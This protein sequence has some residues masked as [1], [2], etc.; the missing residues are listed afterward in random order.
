MKNKSPRLVITGLCLQGNKGGPALGLSLIKALRA[1]IPGAVFI[2]ALPSGKNY[3]HEEQW[4]Q[5]YGVSSFERFDL[6]ELLSPHRFVIHFRDKTRRFSNMFSQFRKADAII[7]LSGVSYVGP[8][9]RKPLASLRGR[10]TFYALSRLAR[11][12]FFAWTQSYGPFGNAFVDRLA[13]SDLKRQKIVF[14]RGDDCARTV[15]SL[16][17]DADTRSFPDVACILP[18][19]PGAKREYVQEKF[20]MLDL[21]KLVTV[22]P[23]AVMYKQNEGEAE[24]NGHIREVIA[25]LEFIESLGLQPLLVP[26]T[27][28]QENARLDNCDNEVA[29]FIKRQRRKDIAVISDD[30][31]P[32]E[33]K[34]VISM[35]RFHIGARYHSLVASLSSGVPSLSLSW[36]DKYKDLL[37]QYEQEEFVGGL[38]GETNNLQL[39]QKLFEN[40]KTIR[41]NIQ[42]RQSAVAE[43][44]A[45]NAILFTG[46]LETA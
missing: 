21:S 38:T 25:L 4:A 22:S 20:P 19:T 16:L 3:R 30:L 39:F 11:R 37:R 2:F 45:E 35:A 7:D 43:A 14:C 5:H 27:L 31:D 24:N 18:F 40:E 8:P 12:P 1:Q 10:F 41:A 42:K 23:S 29:L 32:V 44:V 46:L 33:M 17:P 13:K 6:D 36:H 26:H 34:E 28:R 15:K 9:A